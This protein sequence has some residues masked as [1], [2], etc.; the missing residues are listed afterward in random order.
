M[1]RDP[2]SST[3]WLTFPWFSTLLLFQLCSPEVILTDPE[4]EL[5]WTGFQILLVFPASVTV[6]MSCYSLIKS[7][8]QPCQ[9]LHYLHRDQT[10]VLLSPGENNLPLLSVLI[11]RGLVLIQYLY[12]IR[13]C[14]KLTDCLYHLPS[15]NERNIPFL[16]LLTYEVKHSTW[17]IWALS[18]CF[19]NW[20]K[21]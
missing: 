7:P 1:K 14:A 12:L 11:A 2:D 3:S 4:S 6:F 15:W 18:K 16:R 5:G 17:H 8:A 20:M 10:P 19:F 21:R 13:P 9:Q